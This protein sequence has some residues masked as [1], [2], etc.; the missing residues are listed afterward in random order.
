MYVIQGQISGSKVDPQPTVDLQIKVSWCDD[1]G[2]AVVV[3]RFNTDNATCIG[4]NGEGLQ[5]LIVAS[6]EGHHCG[7][8]RGSI[9]RAFACNTLM[10]LMVRT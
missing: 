1:G 3:E 4:G 7:L 9:L 2:D 10:K 6:V 8:E 5:C